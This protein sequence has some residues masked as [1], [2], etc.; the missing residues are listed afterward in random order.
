MAG[1]AATIAKH[2]PVMVGPVIAYDLACH[3]AGSSDTAKARTWL[4]CAFALDDG[5]ALKL[6]ALDDERLAGVWTE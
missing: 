3:C 2:K 1:R 6:R 4:E 5:K